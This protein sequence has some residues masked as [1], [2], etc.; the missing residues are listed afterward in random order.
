MTPLKPPMLI[1]AFRLSTPTHDETIANIITH[2]STAPGGWN[3]Q[4][5][6]RSIMLA[7]NGAVD[8]AALVSG[9]K[10]VGKPSQVDNAK[11]VE[12]VLPHVIG[13][14]T[15]CFPYKRKHYALTPSLH[16][17][18]GPSFFIVEDGVIKLVYVHAR[19]DNRATLRD[20]AGLATL[21]KSELLD[22]DFY[23][24]PSDVEVHYVD[25]RGDNRFD[26]VHTLS[27]LSSHLTDA[28][29][30]TLG[31]F[32]AALVEVIERDL[33]QQPL[34]RRKEEKPSVGEPQGAFDF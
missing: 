11:I 28:P 17:S 3:H 33:V 20:I 4:R 9:C 12:A 32:A 27:S 31:R 6:L 22:Q 29:S 25:K 30:V 26:D 13:R 8:R 5:C 7:F 10:G 19:N 16:C 34:R 14:R 24:E 23:G 15:Q 18:M 21:L 2:Y 1:D